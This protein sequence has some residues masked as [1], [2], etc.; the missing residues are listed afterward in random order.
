MPP[1]SAPDWYWQLQEL[2]LLEF[3]APSAPPYPK[4]PQD[5]DGFSFT[6]SP[7]VLQILFGTLSQVTLASHAPKIR[8]HKYYSTWVYLGTGPCV[9]KIHPQYKE[10]LLGAFQVTHSLQPSDYPITMIEGT[11]HV[12]MWD[13]VD[14]L[15]EVGC[16]SVRVQSYGMKFDLSD[17]GQY[18]L[19]DI[20]DPE[21]PLGSTN[22]FD[23]GQNYPQPH[24]TLALAPNLPKDSCTTYPMLMR[25]GEGHGS[26]QINLRYRG[27]TFRIKI[28]PLLVHCMKATS[29][30]FNNYTPKFIQG[31]KLK[32]TNLMNRRLKL[33]KF[34]ALK[35][36]GLRVEVTAFGRCLQEAK[37]KVDDS[38]LLDLHQWL[39]PTLPHMANC[40]LRVKFIKKRDYFSNFRELLSKAQHLGVFRGDNSR[41]PGKV[42]TYI[43]QDLFNALGWNSGTRTNRWEKDLGPWWTWVPTKADID[44][45]LEKVVE[46]EANF[47][48]PLL[49]DVHVE[50]I[51]RCT[52]IYKR[53]T[54]FRAVVLDEDG[55]HR[56]FGSSTTKLEL[57][58][59]LFA[60]YKYHWTKYCY[61]VEEPFPSS[62]STPT[63]DA[64]LEKYNLLGTYVIG[65]L[66]LF[67]ELKGSN[68]YRVT[69]GYIRGDGNC[70]F[71]VLSKV[72]YG[73]Q[74]HHPKVRQLVVK[75]LQENRDKVEA[76]VAAS[77]LRQTAF[78]PARTVDAYLQSMANLGTWGDDATLSAAVHVFNLCLVV[79]N[80]DL[81]HFELRKPGTP[82]DDVQWHA[83]YYTGNHYELV[84]RLPFLIPAQAAA[85]AARPSS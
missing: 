14:K 12:T 34:P 4:L 9:L 20:G 70:Q 32:E 7:Y 57:A 6:T 36:G 50:E 68:N 65:P 31:M 13:L 55:K 17:L 76:V 72:V 74:K 42:R 64:E 37:A 18:Q 46:P 52:K 23:V 38:R 3:P 61:L 83:V 53:G 45:A 48:N 35:L 15:D 21:H 30:K 26:L 69:S 82:A 2:G 79:I 54:K 1:S 67:H 77:D 33:A 84:Y 39:N 25:L 10:P 58:K 44:S 51:L 49:E 43:L 81:T 28:Y 22:F 29:G 40:Q 78:T 75:Y 63:L 66:E 73:H 56:N 24:I 71:R 16:T 59:I 85:Q 11:Q 47:R 19:E 27:D 62:Q 60:K 8:D 41:K 80:T 5:L